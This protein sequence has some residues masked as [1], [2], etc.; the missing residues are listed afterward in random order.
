MD[1]I[2]NLIESVSMGFPTYFC[3]SQVVFS[4]PFYIR[5]L[6]FLTNNA[7]FYIP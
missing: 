1:E 2:L 7:I 3:Q 5:L 6:D 4:L